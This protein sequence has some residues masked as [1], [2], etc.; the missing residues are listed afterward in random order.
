MIK[1]QTLLSYS[2]SS[3]IYVKLSV[4]S[5]FFLFHIDANYNEHQEC[6]STWLIYSFSFHSDP[7]SEEF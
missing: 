3:L 5:F 7:S 2:P 6:T 1:L 4:I